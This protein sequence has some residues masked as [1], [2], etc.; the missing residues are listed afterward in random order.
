MGFKNFYNNLL[1]ATKGQPK[2]TVEMVH[3]EVDLAEGKI[4]EL[5]KKLLQDT[6]VSLSSDESKLDK[7]QKL[8]FTNALYCNNVNITDPTETAS[9]K[10]LRIYQQ[11]KLSYPLEKIIKFAEFERIC[12]KYNLI[13]ATANCYIRDIPEKNLDEILNTTPTRVYDLERYLLFVSRINRGYHGHLDFIN[14]LIKLLQNRPLFQRFPSVESIFDFLK[15]EISAKYINDEK[16]F[17]SL[18]W[19]DIRYNEIDLEKNPL[20]I[21]APSSHFDADLL[22]ENKFQMPIQNVL[23][24]DPIAFNILE[25]GFVR[26]LSKWGTEDDQSYLDP[27]LT[28]EIQN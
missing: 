8:G 11:Y 24:P 5:L 7:M 12:K 25:K 10:E 20:L 4:S 27:A 6:K 18:S 23:V 22:K 28:N 17:K 2:Y 16:Y 1:K 13:W 15:N 3:E 14:H 19:S 21:A 26:I 9:V